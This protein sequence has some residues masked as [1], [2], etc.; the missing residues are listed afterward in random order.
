MQYIYIMKHGRDPFPSNDGFPTSHQHSTTITRGEASDCCIP[1]EL[2]G[3]S[4]TNN[5]AAP[6]SFSPHAEKRITHRDI[7]N[8]PNSPQSLTG[9]ESSPPWNWVSFTPS[10]NTIVLPS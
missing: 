7:K 2:A 4:S 9:Y 3:F 10:P 1:F 6:Q 5:R 8:R